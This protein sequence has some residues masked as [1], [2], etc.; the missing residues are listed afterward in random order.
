[1]YYRVRTS[2]LLHT[3][4]VCPVHWAS[5]RNMYASALIRYPIRVYPTIPVGMSV[6]ATM[7]KRSYAALCT[8]IVCSA[9]RMHL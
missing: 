7:L 4:I 2:G 3:R 8:V 5:H 6:R 9:V 1:M